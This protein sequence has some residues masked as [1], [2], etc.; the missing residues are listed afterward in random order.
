MK[1]TS[2]FSECL[3]QGFILP[4]ILTRVITDST[5]RWTQVPVVFTHGVLQDVCTHLLLVMDKELV[6][7]FLNQLVHF[8]L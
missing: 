4:Q 8:D 1:L 2:T 3:L 7:L 5:E 6:D